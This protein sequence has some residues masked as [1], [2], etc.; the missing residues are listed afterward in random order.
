MLG[1]FVD[2]CFF[3]DFLCLED[4]TR[5]VIN[6]YK[7]KTDKIG[8]P[9]NIELP[10]KIANICTREIWKNNGM[11]CCKSTYTIQQYIYYL[12]FHGKINKY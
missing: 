9:L 2:H 12:H 7:V 6:L 11:Y 4:S 8:V 1:V 10:K 3:G 5:R